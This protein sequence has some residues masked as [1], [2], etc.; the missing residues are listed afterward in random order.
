MSGRTR[1]DRIVEFAKRLPVAAIVLR[2][3]YEQAFRSADG[4][5]LWYG[6]Y[7]TFAAAVAAAPDRVPVG[8]DQ[9]STANMYDEARYQT[10]AAQDYPV[11]FWLARECR[12]SSR[13]FDF[14][15]HVGVL[16][17]AYRR[18]LPPDRMPS[19]TVC[20][21]PA[22]AQV[23]AERAE[24]Q[25]ETS[26][27]FTTRFSDA[28]A[29]DVLLVSGALQYIETPLAT[30]VGALEKRPPY[31]LLNKLPTAKR[32]HITLQ[33]IGVAYCPYRIAA[34]S[35]LPALLSDAG[36]EQVDEWENPG[37]HRTSLPYSDAGP[38]TWVGACYRLR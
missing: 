20:D 36:Y 19:W 18:Y 14:G 22:V 12:A 9:P 23:G 38:I 21:V 1:L 4:H 37:E 5:N 10:V 2:R 30:M 26:L 3:R 15:G 24:A 27:R 16:Y 8:Y 29:A 35:D 6:V 7:P 31:V 33:N 17:Y 25:G 28:D 32:E 34:R 13:L 11:L